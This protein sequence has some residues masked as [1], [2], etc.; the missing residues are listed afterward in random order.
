MR[1]PLRAANKPNSKSK[2]I[3]ADPKRPL[4]EQL[5]NLRPGGII[6]LRKG[7]YRLNPSGRKADPMKKPEVTS[8][9]VASI[10]GR[11][12]KFLEKATEDQS[13]CLVTVSTLT[14]RTLTD[15]LCSPSELRALAASALTQAEDKPKR[16]RKAMIADIDSAMKSFMRCDNAITKYN[17]S[18]VNPKRKKTARKGTK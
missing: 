4:S 9:K 18:D 6:K 5:K 14:G 15:K 12:L 7:T 10:A 11:I 2:I 3:F 8:K 16:N 1:E 17:F 13:I